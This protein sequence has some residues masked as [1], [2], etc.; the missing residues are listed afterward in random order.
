MSFRLWAKAASANKIKPLYKEMEVRCDLDV[1]NITPPQLYTFL[2]E[3]LEKY[4]EL[5]F[6][7]QS[8]LDLEFKNI[9]PQSLE[10]VLYTVYSHYSSVPFSSKKEQKP[11]HKWSFE[12][13][14][15]KTVENLVDAILKAR[16]LQE[17]PPNLLY[18]KKFVERAKEMLSGLKNVSVQVFD[19]KALLE[20]KLNLI[21]EVGKAS[22][23]PP[24]LM[25]VEYLPNPNEKSKALVGKGISYDT[26]G[27]NLKP[28]SHMS[29]MKFDMSGAASSLA[30]I[31]AMA[32]N[33]VSE[34]LRVFLPLAENCVSSNAY[35]PDD[36]IISYSGKSVEVDNT[37]AE[38]RLVLADALSYAAMEYSPTEIIS[39]ATL[40]GA[41][42]YALGN[43]YGGAWATSEESWKSLYDSSIA[44][45]EWI[46]RMPL[47]DYYLK[48][49]KKSRVADLKNSARTGAGGSSRAACFLKEF[50]LGLPY[51]HLDIANIAYSDSTSVSYAPMVRTLYYYL[52]ERR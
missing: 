18:P 5:S 33:E 30:V 23:N 11:S 3:S 52:A 25:V 7:F 16:Q 14:I 26:G 34:N 40:T 19:Q 27:L 1:K 8:F 6:D 13:S 35:R 39:I 48:A 31:Y 37:D 36:V 44:A 47:D 2:L 50:V 46:W 22:E 17:C 4:D 38:G 51:V 12:G 45:G 20:K 9:T 28:G 41:I 24:Y 49:L 29:N 10:L 15:S 21:N 42:G 32:K 43:K